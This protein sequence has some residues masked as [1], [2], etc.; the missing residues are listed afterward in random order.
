MPRQDVSARCSKV[1][2]ELAENLIPWG[3][4]HTD[5]MVIAK[6]SSDEG[7]TT[8]EVV[9]VRPIQMLPTASVF[10]YGMS[11]FEGM[12]AYIDLSDGQGTKSLEESGT[13]CKPSCES[14]IVRLFR[15]EYHAKRLEASAQRMGLPTFDPELLV[16]EI[17]R[18][19]QTERDAGWVPNMRGASLYIRPVIFAC[20]ESLGVRRSNAAMMVITCHPVRGYFRAGPQTSSTGLR[21]LV[22]R[23][24]VRA[25]PGGVGFAKTGGNYARCIVP[26]EHAQ[27]KGYDQI[28]W[29]EGGSMENPGDS[30]VGECGQM[31]FMWVEKQGS[32]LVIVTPALDGCILAGA[33][34]DTILRVAAELNIVARV[35]ERTVRLR[36][37]LEGIECGDVVDMFGTGTGAVVSHVSS[38]C[39]EN[40][41]YALR[42][43]SQMRVSIKLREALVQSYHSDGVWMRNVEELAI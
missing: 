27:A 25:E 21:L 5:N 24:H 29:V 16:N 20:E 10:H 12:K 3:S 41:T 33:T 22:D 14:D 37:L 6:W 31:N 8:P 13:V 30:I 35:E 17:C 9:P 42:K 40:K 18:L 15:P 1:M 38:I 28:L 23:N 26:T 7:W 19:V 2:N 34:R 43:D 39:V 4:V 32:E 36:E 11:V